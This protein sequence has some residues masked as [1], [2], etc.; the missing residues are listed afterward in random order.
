MKTLFR[1]LLLLFFLS[2]CIAGS[3]FFKKEGIYGGSILDM[4]KSGEYLYTANEQGIGIVSVKDPLNLEEK[5]FYRTDNTVLSLKI[6]KEFNK[7]YA[8]IKGEGLIIY[9]LSDSPYLKK[10][11]EFKEKIDI[12]DIEIENGYAYL[13]CGENGLYILDISNPSVVFLAGKLDTPGFADKILLRGNILFLADQNFGVEVVNVSDKSRPFFESK[14]RLNHKKI[15]IAFKNQYLYISNYEQGI[16]VMDMSN[17]KTLDWSKQASFIHTDTY[18]SKILI[19]GETLFAFEGKKRVRIMSVLSPLNPMTLSEYESQYEPVLLIKSKE[20]LFLSV[21]EGGIESISLKNIQKPKYLSRY[22]GENVYIKEV[23]LRGNYAFT[24]DSYFGMH[25]IDI[26]NRKDPYM[27]AFLD[28]NSSIEN[29]HINKRYAYLSLKDN[30][31][32]IVDILDAKNPKIVNS[33]KTKFSPKSSYKKGDFL[34]ISEGKGGFEIFNIQDPKKPLKAGEFLTNS[35]ASKIVV[36]NDYAYVAQGK[37]GVGIVDVSYPFLPFLQNRINIG[38]EVTDIDIKDQFLYATCKNCFK[39]FNI[40]DINLPLLKGSYKLTGEIESLDLQRGYAL[41]SVK[42]DGIKLLNIKDFTN[43]YQ[44]G[45]IPLKESKKAVIE[46]DLLLSASYEKGLRLYSVFAHTA[47]PKNLYAFAIGE[48]R[49]YIFWDGVENA[50]GYYLRRE[51]I[52]GESQIVA[53][54]KEDAEDF[55]DFSLKP[56]TSYRYSLRVITDF[57]VS[58]PVFSNTIHTEGG[59]A[60]NPPS[61]FIAK[62]ES[63]KSVILRWRDNSDNENAFYIT[64]I[65]SKGNKEMIGIA[66]KNTTLFEDKKVKDGETYQYEIV[67]VNEFGKSTAVKSN[68]VTIEKVSPPKAPSNFKAEFKNQEI[69]LTWEDN[70]DNEDSFIITRKNPDGTFEKIATLAANTTS[71]TDKDIEMGKSYQYD[72]AA[73]NRF[74]ISKRVISNVVTTTQNGDIPNAPEDFKARVLDEKS[75]KLTWK[76]NSNNENGFYITRKNPDGTLSVVAFVEANKTEYIDKDVKAGESYSYQILAINDNGI[77]EWVESNKV[78]IPGASSPNPPSS[79]EVKVLEDKSVEIT[80]EDNSGNEIGFYLE[81]QEDNETPI[82]IAIL[83]ADTTSFKDI[84]VKEGATYK[85]FVSAFNDFGT[86]KKSESTDITI[87]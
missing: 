22:I 61:D 41:L 77:S 62:V 21:K 67:A 65:D 39:I 54:L 32:L 70:S 60:P 81:R 68:K 53:L 18:I 58:E 59:E 55:E 85:Y 33:I 3:V 76:D 51:E 75:V 63:E 5:L 56:N 13:A 52:G 29:I 50:K 24:A 80:W 84:T 23:A 49:A 12:Y 78:K 20:L 45:Y 19:D 36:K 48:S 57:G 30:E 86:S 16:S 8:G 46:E 34:Y 9:T 44:E 79:V 11:G 71:Y 6:D 28:T 73:V 72:I 27:I 2:G 38:G 15:D 74:G 4:E 87:K 82:V 26:S 17:P 42:G 40:S 43:I 7:L 83:D 69:F 35:E 64:R 66:P 1:V 14:L 31:V 10:T 25:V 37:G 47:L